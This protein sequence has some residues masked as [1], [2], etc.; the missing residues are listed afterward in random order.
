[1]STKI[2]FVLDGKIVSIDFN[3]EKRYTPTTTVLNYLRSLPNHR[4]AKEGC[5]EG[6]CGACT[7]VLGEL[8]P[9]KKIHYKAIDSCLVFLPL[10]H[11]KQLITVESLK[12]SDQ[13][14]H[15]VQQ[16]LVDTHGSQCGFCTPGIIM[17][18]FALYKSDIK[19]SRLNIEQA[20]SGN[21][22]RCTGY[23]PIIEAA[24]KVCANKKI[25]QF[26]K[27][28]EK[29]LK[30][31]HQID[32]GSLSLKKRNQKYYCPRSVNDALQIRKKHPKA[33]IINGAT[34]IALRV[35]KNHE[36]LPEIIDLSFISALK[37]ISHKKNS[38]E[39]MAG[40]TL[41]E[42]K[43]H[44]K[45]HFPAFYKMLTVFG[46]DQIRNMATIGGN[47][48]TASPIGDIAPLLMAYNAEIVL[49]SKKKK[50]RLAINDF[51]I[52]YRKTACRKNELVY[53]VIFPRSENNT[54]INFYKFSKRK[55]LDI[56]T[57][58]GG[59]R[60]E[61]SKDNRVKS[62]KLAFGGMAEQ[63]R[64]AVKT[65]KF[66]I[67]NQWNKKI[68]EQSGDILEKEFSPISDARASAA[69]RTVAAKNLLLKFW[70]DTKKE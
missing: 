39:I 43:D 68:V 65:E 57:V 50:R 58:S 40:T 10:L 25:D 61:L 29:V 20:L 5:A 17:S 70:S 41:N 6:D 63:T 66:L 33:T 19:P 67:G 11:G 13:N 45:N 34:D 7:V 62:L 48:A 14:L 35:T 38:T 47:L 15:P 56:S 60:L 54:L 36:K 32:R 18:L 8:G 24:E 2:S 4:G 59:F 21:L 51:I 55:D 37:G 22:C 30:L 69:G 44:A 31:L 9:Q 46:S 27:D 12:S 26:S 1:M 52:G 28:E 23:V 42:I 3:K 16:T 53:S 64:R 49:V